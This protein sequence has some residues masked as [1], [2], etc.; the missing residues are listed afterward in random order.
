M[1]IRDTSYFGWKNVF[2]SPVSG[3]F[4]AITEDI[5]GNI[6]VAGYYQQN[7]SSNIDVSLLRS[8]N[9]GD[10][11]TAIPILTGSSTSSSFLYSALD[12]IS[13]IS[14]SLFVTHPYHNGILKFTDLGNSWN[15]YLT[16]GSFLAP[17]PIYS[18]AVDNLSRKFIIYI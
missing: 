14:G 17:G 5:L 7:L 16:L 2:Q 4:S 6:Y 15:P 1:G 9:N 18:L 12:L 13:D 10:S 11:W 3:N 8:N